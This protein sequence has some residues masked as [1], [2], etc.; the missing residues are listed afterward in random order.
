MKTLPILLLV[1]AVAAAGAAPTDGP[2]S[3]STDDPP[4]SDSTQDGVQFD[5][6][7]TEPSTGHLQTTSELRVPVE[8]PIIVPQ[9]VEPLC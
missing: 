5:E 4:A 7:G 3:P 2:P 1:L 6:E 8:E 9:H